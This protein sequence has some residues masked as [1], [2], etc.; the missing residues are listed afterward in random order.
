MGVYGGEGAAWQQL[1]NLVLD[2]EQTA[3]LGCLSSTFQSLDSCVELESL[4]ERI[5]RLQ[6]ESKAREAL[7][8]PDRDDG[9][10]WRGRVGRLGLEVPWG[11]GLR[12]LLPLESGFC[13]W[14]IVGCDGEISGP[15]DLSCYVRDPNFG[16][17]DFAQR[18]EDQTQIFRVQVGGAAAVLE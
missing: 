11:N 14:S 4:R 16:Y 13:S 1:K 12:C 9:N 10:K 6:V 3:N 17:Q 18:D 2:P 5:H 7:R 15:A 8:L